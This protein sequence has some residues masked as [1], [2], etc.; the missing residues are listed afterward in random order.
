MSTDMVT[1][2]GHRWTLQLRTITR[3]L[4]VSIAGSMQ[5][6]SNERDTL[7]GNPSPKGAMQ[8]YYQ[9]I[10]ASGHASQYEHL[11][12]TSIFHPSNP[13]Q[14]TANTVNFRK[15]KSAQACN[16]CKL[17]NREAKRDMEAKHYSI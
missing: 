6:S 11:G 7:T 8:G 17:T 9:R 13:I 14:T 2:S 12:T 15:A 5:Q 3:D 1:L 16:F 4:P 10:S